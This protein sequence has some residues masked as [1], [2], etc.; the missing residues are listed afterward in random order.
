MLIKAAYTGIAALIIE[1]KTTHTIAMISQHNLHKALSEESKR[2]LQEFWREYAYL[3]I[4]E[5][6]MISKTFF[7]LLSRI[8]SIAK[9]TVGV[10][11]PTDSFGGINVIICGDFHQFPPVAAPTYEALYYPAN[12]QKDSADALLGRAIYEEFVTVVILKEQIRCVDPVWLDF[13][14]HLRDGRVQEHHIKLLEGLVLNDP[15][16]PKTDF[17]QAPWQN[18]GLVTPR[19]AVR[20]RWN[21]SAVR[22]HCQLS[23]NQLF[24][25]EAEDT[26]K[27]RELDD[28]EK[29]ALANRAW[30]NPQSKKRLQLPAKVELAIG[31]KVMVTTNIETDL[32]ITNGARGVIVDVVLNPGEIYSKEA[33]EVATAK[34]PLYLLVKL[35]WTRTTPLEGLQEAVIP[36]EPMTQTLQIQ[37][38][39]KDGKTIRRTVKRRQF[40]VTPAYAFTDYR[41]Q[42]QTIP[43]VIVDIATPPTGGLNLFNLYVTLSRSSG[44][45]SIRLLRDFDSK[46]FQAAHS[47]DL[48]AED[49][50]LKALDAETQKQWETMGR[51]RKMSD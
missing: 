8:I 23:G 47:A 20:M 49:D 19:H 2:K 11:T 38:A 16:C 28:R 18:A 42:G 5:M 9:T 17:T 4:D 14:Q 48:L 37:L 6:S 30:Q 41:A 43:Y 29:D 15:Q 25:C 21:E 26:I 10:D 32:D 45:S 27:G 1:G 35:D 7:A 3:I 36:V 33:E 22:K 39:G 24:V 31:M 44:R 13:L 40:P 34:L 50:R 46:V 51:G 12:I